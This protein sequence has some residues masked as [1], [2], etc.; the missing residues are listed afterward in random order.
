MWETYKTIVCTDNNGQWRV[1]EH[2]RVHENLIVGY[3]HAISVKEEFDSSANFCQFNLHWWSLD[4]ST[5]DCRDDSGLK[6]T[7]QKNIYLEFISEFISLQFV[8]F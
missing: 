1:K 3:V 4:T 7:K 5:D 8:I 6:K 2:L